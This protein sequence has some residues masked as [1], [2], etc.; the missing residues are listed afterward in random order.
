MTASGPKQT[1]D[2]K[3]EMFSKIKNS[4][5][6]IKPHLGFLSGLL[7][8]E[9]DINQCGCWRKSGG[10]RRFL[11]LILASWLAIFPLGY[12]PE[13]TQLVL[14][15]HPTSGAALCWEKWKQKFTK[16]L[17]APFSFLPTRDQPGEE[18]GS[19]CLLWPWIL[20]WRDG[21]ALS[22]GLKNGTQVKRM[23]GLWGPWGWEIAC[24]GLCLSWFTLRGGRADC[25]CFPC[26]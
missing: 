3:L 11:H 26:S 25:L 10:P 12:L 2:C 5:P 18:V 7:L 13:A 17:S 20:T 21:Q 16:V 23:G 19:L 1:R 6:L 14:T 4:P 9:Q 15:C 22:V 8:I 24:C